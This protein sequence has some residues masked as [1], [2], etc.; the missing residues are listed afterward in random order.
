MVGSPGV[1]L[2]SHRAG[3]FPDP[4]SGDGSVQNSLP[5]RSLPLN[6][7]K[8]TAALQSLTD[9]VTTAA[10]ALLRIG[11]DGPDRLTSATAYVV[12]DVAET[13]QFNVDGTPK[14]DAEGKPLPPVKRDRKSLNIPKLSKK[15]TGRQANK[16][17][18]LPIPASFLLSLPTDPDLRAMAFVAAI[19][20]ALIS[21]QFTGESA[22]ALRA[23]LCLTR[24]SKSGPTFLF[25][26]GMEVPKA[27]IPALKA[28]VL[29]TAPDAFLIALKRDAEPTRLML[30]CSTNAAAEDKNARCYSSTVPIRHIDV[31][32]PGGSAPKCFRC[33]A[34]WNIFV[35]KGEAYVP[36]TADTVAL[37]GGAEHFPHPDDVNGPISPEDEADRLI[38]RRNAQLREAV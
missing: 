9:A 8:L 23:G 2:H 6:L 32:L 28:S 22:K 31:H 38:A 4:A 10:N 7:S 25:P 37:P 24:P 34:S 35:R 16:G 29:A 30:E 1:R 13:A 21:A 3:R 11:D 33:G 36:P 27:W 20:D 5:L 18:L 15:Q 17:L 12:P 26:A 14:V 19:V